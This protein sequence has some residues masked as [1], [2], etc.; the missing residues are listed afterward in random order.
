MKEVPINKPELLKKLDAFAIIGSLAVLV[1]VILM[2][3]IKIDVGVE[4]TFL[5]AFHAVLN[6]FVSIFLLIAL[7]AIKNRKI[8]L[9]KKFILTAMSFSILFLLSY[10]IYHI[11]SESTTYCM[12]GG[13]RYLYFFLLITHVVLAAI[14]LPFIL[15]TFNRAWTDNFETHKRMARVVFP[16]WFYV[17]I[18]GP[19][20]YLMIRPCY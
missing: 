6:T 9:H 20:V 16:I 15:F 12:T 11:T 19:V 4:L 3:Q 10:V 1:L 7:W 18:T 2:R 8:D 14:I 17:A 13:I 5:P